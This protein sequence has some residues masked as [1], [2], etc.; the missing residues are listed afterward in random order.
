MLAIQYASGIL[1]GWVVSDV[2]SKFTF[3]SSG[4]PAFKRAIP[5]FISCFEYLRPNHL[6]T[7]ASFHTYIPY[8]LRTGNEIKSI[9]TIQI[10]QKDRQKADSIKI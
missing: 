1:K 5:R 10:R 4:I 2:E 8:L 9:K 6:F 7:T 3:K